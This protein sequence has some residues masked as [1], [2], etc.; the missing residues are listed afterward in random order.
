MDLQ[1]YIEQFITINE[2][3]KELSCELYSAI[4]NRF[5]ISIPYK[6]YLVL[7]E[8]QEKVFTFVEDL[9][10]L[11]INFIS[12]AF[13]YLLQ[14]DNYLVDVIIMVWCLPRPYLCSSKKIYRE[15][16]SQNIAN[17]SF[18]LAAIIRHPAVENF[19]I[20][21]LT[22]NNYVPI[23]CIDYIWFYM[24]NISM[25]FIFY[26]SENSLYIGFIMPENGE[27]YLKFGFNMEHLLEMGLGKIVYQNDPSSKGSFRNLLKIFVTD[28][29]LV[30]K[31]LMASTGHNF[32]KQVI[33]ICKDPSRYF[34]EILK[35]IPKDV[36]N[37][38]E[39]S[40]GKDYS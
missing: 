20:E 12:D 2:I 35:E 18:K 37:E 8:Y 16:Y 14:K 3:E 22:K 11:E 13:N 1:K 34:G 26:N 9:R 31:M 7:K 21:T 29:Y 27:E 10:E 15:I 28:V 19:C 36:S 39:K 25:E 38:I 5:A 24:S 40:F 23:H 33:N 17:Y 4:L 6:R 30:K 32:R